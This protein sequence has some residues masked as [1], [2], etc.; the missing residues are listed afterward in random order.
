MREN[1]KGTGN[2]QSKRV[3]ELEKEL[4][5]VKRKSGTSEVEIREQR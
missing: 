4:N 2:W 5:K 3:K 1:E